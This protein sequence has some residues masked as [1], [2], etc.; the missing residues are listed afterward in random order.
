MLY[1]LPYDCSSVRNSYCVLVRYLFDNK[2]K[3]SK[4]TQ[5]A[6]V[7]SYFLTTARK[8]YTLSIGDGPEQHFLDRT[9]ETQPHETSS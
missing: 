7:K 9:S 3:V 2:E 6:K 5:R 4:G 1:I 8:S